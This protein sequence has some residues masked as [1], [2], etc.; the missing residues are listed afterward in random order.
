MEAP[1]YKLIGYFY[2]NLSPTYMA[3]IINTLLSDRK[4]EFVYVNVRQHLNPRP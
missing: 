1:K 2:Y 4:R 3:G